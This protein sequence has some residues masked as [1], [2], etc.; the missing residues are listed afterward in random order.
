[1]DASTIRMSA[2]RAAACGPPA[3]Q[4]AVAYG[5][6]QGQQ[7]Y[8]RALPA[9]SRSAGEVKRTTQEIFL[10]AHMAIL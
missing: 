8:R 4:D 6:W 10:L 9:S 3:G 1:M 2:G 7:A 5:G